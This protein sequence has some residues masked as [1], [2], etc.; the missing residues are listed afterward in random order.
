MITKKTCFKCNLDKPISDYYKHKQMADGYLGKCKEC[1]QKDTKTRT[2]SLIN[3][4]SWVEKEQKRGREKYHRLGYK[5]TQ[6]PKTY[7]GKINTFRAK[8]P[9]KYKAHSATSNME[10]IIE[11]NELHHWSYNEAHRKDI[12]ELS[13]KD[14]NKAHRFIVYDQEQMM[15]RRIDNNELLNTKERHIE[16]INHC[17]KTKED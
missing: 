5:V 17:I 7:K 2:N 3:D 6:K 1:T 14:H 16:W 9:E 13:C 15:Y 12:I 11:G 4:P 10:P 8:Y